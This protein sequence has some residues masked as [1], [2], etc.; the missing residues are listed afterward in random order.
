MTQLWHS[1][2]PSSVRSAQP[3][4]DTSPLQGIWL[5]WKHLTRAEQVVSACIVLIPFWWILGWLWMLPAL[6][7]CIAIHDLFY[8][9][10]LRL[11][12]PTVETWALLTFSLYVFI[13]SNLRAPEFIPSSLINPIWIFAALTLW[14]VQSNDI[15]IRPQVMAWA[16]SASVVQMIAFWLVIHF[17]LSEPSYVPYRTIIG[18][19]TDK[20]ETFIPGTGNANYLRPYDPDEKGLGG[21]ARFS[22]FF[23]HPFPCVLVVGFAAF[24]GL[25][26]KNKS[27]A[28]YMTLA[29][30]FL[31]FLTQT[32]SAWIAFPIILIARYFSNRSKVV[33]FALISVISFGALSLPSITDALSNRYTSTV[34]ATSNFRRDSSEVRALIYKRTWDRLPEEFLLGHGI[35][36]PTVLPGF[37]AGR[38]GSHSFFLGTLL[39]KSGLLGTAVFTT[40][41]VSLL[42]WL[43]KT[44]AGRPRCCFLIFIYLGMNLLFEEP[45]IVTVLLV[46]LCTL[47]REPEIA[48][49]RGLHD[50]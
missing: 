7:V 40:F 49:P 27:W 24:L 15:R 21:L 48:P 8:H 22:F 5:Q 4:D 26:M 34:E 35:N 17:V 23:S 19:L 31:L 37:D 28:M 3:E 45:E 9:G 39:Y 41:L 18:S 2:L 6:V 16:F 36:G 44:K 32:R 30:S 38:I 50:A 13:N 46:L 47:I 29:C 20:S 1:P 11:K 14:Y 42:L 43:D 12:P 25:D 10:T 33:L